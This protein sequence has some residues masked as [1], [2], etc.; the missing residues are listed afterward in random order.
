MFAKITKFLDRLR[1]GEDAAKKRWLVVLSG[2]TM[3]LVIA[4]WAI[5]FNLTTPK[6]YRAEIVQAGNQTSNN[7]KAALANGWR[8]V[9]D[10]LGGENYLTIDNV[11]RNFVLE[12]IEEIPKTSL[13]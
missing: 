1:N 7:V 8:A 6:L 12:N 10:K 13:P 11:E 9:M 2:I 5:Y 3:V 4:L